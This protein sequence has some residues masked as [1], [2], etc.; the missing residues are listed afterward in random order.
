MLILAFDTTSPQ[1]SAVLARGREQLA[2]VR[3]DGQVN[4]SVVLFEMVDRLLGIAGLTLDCVGLF[5][6]ANGPG[7]FTGIRVGLAAAQ[8]WA[9]AFARPVCGVSVLE[10]MVAAADPR[11]QVAISL[12][13]ARR[14]EFYCGIF[15]REPAV[16][17]EE[18]RFDLSGE[19]M[20]LNASG[21][22]ALAES[23][24]RSGEREAVFITREDDQAARELAA[25]LPAEWTTVS[26][27]QAA[28]IARVAL[29][30]A[31]D[32]RLQSPEDLDAFY[33]RR[34]DAELNWRE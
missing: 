10:A 3:S 13:D 2:E 8:G 14:S 33:I 9:G 5:A 4:Y 26:N 19:G 27:H 16:E 25:Q 24:S 34:P 20:V 32:G 30:A 6:A 12:L 17:L 15:R 23:L 18:A 22:V 1:G 11:G 7:S 28:A 31:R 29:R 21:V